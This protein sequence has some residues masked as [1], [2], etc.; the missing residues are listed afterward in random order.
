VI[1]KLFDC[2]PNFSTSTPSPSIFAPEAAI[3]ALGYLGNR[4]P[5]T[6]ARLFDLLSHTSPQIR[7]SAIEVIGQ[8]GDG[9]PEII[10]KLIEL[11]SSTGLSE[12]QAA[13]IALAKQSREP[14]Q[15]IDILL[16]LLVN[17]LD[18]RIWGSA[19]SYILASFKVDRVALSQQLEKLLYDH[20]PMT[21]SNL[22]ATTQADFVFFALQQIVET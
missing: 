4:E 20:E 9:Q 3:E 1:A 6:L 8:L 17:P 7:T 14:T 11:L 19:L 16:K 18:K 15:V 5:E 12:R 22:Y 21:K 10:A 2:L 13:L